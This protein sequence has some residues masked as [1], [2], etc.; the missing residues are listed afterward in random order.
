MY[1]LFIIGYYG[2]A[3]ESSKNKLKNNNQ[4]GVD[5]EEIEYD[6]LEKQES[7]N[8]KTFIF[9]QSDSNYDPIDEVMLKAYEEEENLVLEIE[10]VQNNELLS[11]LAQEAKLTRQ[12]SVERLIHFQHK[13][14]KKFKE[15]TLNYNEDKE[16]EIDTTRTPIKILQM[17]KDLSRK[18]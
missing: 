5:D 9:K 13:K 14:Y 2:L 10:K 6:D 11:V 7:N 16:S 4:K 3:K 12:L 8:Y 15:K 1:K 17:Q 18:A